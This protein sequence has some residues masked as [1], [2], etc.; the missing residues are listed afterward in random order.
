MVGSLSTLHQKTAVVTGAS[1]GVGRAIALR[2]ARAG[3]NLALIA[4]DAEALNEVKDEVEGCGGTAMTI[5]IDVANAEAVIQAAD[6][7]VMSFGSIDVWINN[8][9]WSRCSRQYGGSLR[10]N[11]AA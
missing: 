4:R 6:T 11:S 8:A 5:A 9:I 3:A 7:I 10:R 2:L 1:A